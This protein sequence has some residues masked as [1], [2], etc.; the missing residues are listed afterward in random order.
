MAA[1]AAAG[2]LCRVIRA[3]A[4]GG[5]LQLLHRLHISQRGQERERERE[6]QQA[7]FAG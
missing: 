5:S 7:T 6:Q 2:D 4:I 1:R 3:I